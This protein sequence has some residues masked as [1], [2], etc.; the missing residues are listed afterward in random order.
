MTESSSDAPQV[1][2]GQAVFNG[3]GEQLGTISRV[4]EEGFRVG[5][6]DGVTVHPESLPPKSGEVELVWRCAVCGEMG[7]IEE[8]PDECP[9][10]DAPREDLYY[11]IED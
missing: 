7:E 3:S 2:V 1:A 5:F 10:C 6:E 8:L 9:N 11:W 4:D